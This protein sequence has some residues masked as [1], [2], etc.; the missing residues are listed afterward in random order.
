[1]NNEIPC[2]DVLDSPLAEAI[3]KHISD[4]RYYFVF[5]SQIAADSWAQAVFRHPEI[6]ALEPGRFLSWDRFLALIREKPRNE[7]I[8]PADHY[9]RYLWACGALK[10]N[11]ENPF[12]RALVKPDLAPPSRYPAWLASIANRLNFMEDIARREYNSESHNAEILDFIILS[13]K[14][15]IFLERNNL[16]EESSLPLRFPEK[17]KFI[18][19]GASAYKD[20]LWYRSMLEKSGCTE[21]FDVIPAEPGR[22]QK[23]HRFENFR[24]EARWIFA[25]IRSMLNNGKTPGDFAISVPALQP[26][27]K[28]YLS[29]FAHEYDISITFRVGEKLSSSPFGLLLNLIAAAIDDTLSQQSV[30]ALARQTLFV[31]KQPGAFA[32]LMEFSRMFSIPRKN[33]GKKFMNRV[34][35]MTF[36]DAQFEG[37][38]AL[39]D[40]YLLLQKK[41]SAIAAAASFQSLREALFDFRLTFIEDSGISEQSEKLLA[42]IFEELISLERAAQSL[43]G[44]SLTGNTFQRFRA[45]LDTIQYAPD[46]SDMAVSVY[47]YHSG[48]LNAAPVHFVLDASQDAVDS[49]QK[50]PSLPE[51]IKKLLP[52]DTSYESYILRSFDCVNAIYCFADTALSGFCVPHPWFSAEHIQT[53]FVNEEK[54]LN[55]LSF[56]AREKKAWIENRPENLQPLT[57]GQQNAALGIFDSELNGQPLPPPLFDQRKTDTRQTIAADNVVD[58]IAPALH[59]SS[60][61]INPAALGDYSACPFRWFLAYIVRLQN[62]IPSEPLMIGSIL[63]DCIKN[64]VLRISSKQPVLRKE[65]IQAYSD[66]VID[67]IQQGIDYQTRKSGHGARPF[68]EAHFRRMTSRLLT[69]LD[70]EA[71]LQ[72]AGWTVGEFEKSFEKHFE[73]LSVIFNGRT[74]RLM[75]RREGSEMACLLIDY[76]KKYIPQ[77]KHLL[78]DEKTGQL[79]ELQIPGYILLLTEAG[80]LVVSAFYYSIENAKKQVVLGDESR[81]AAPDAQSYFK[82]L[83]ALRAMLEKASEGIW[84]G[85]ITAA[86]PFTKTCSN[87][88]YRPICRANYSSERH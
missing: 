7:T 50:F 24:T 2:R 37:K 14:Y 34:W 21:F 25:N 62:K 35:S 41:L 27:M 58:C 45:F 13:E 56:H 17:S 6:E 54:Q 3:V 55:A 53:V 18:L 85:R 76:K 68:L 70:L 12:L 39:H 84:S 66:L 72:E 69:Y 80:F 8:R 61:K 52:D 86:S 79:A 31:W 19:F 46:S 5:P 48:I 77:K 42:R 65:A 22:S 9:T 74:D 73:Q 11:A 38:A 32:K 1:M 28:A 40:F 59:G 47:P 57:F 64:I 33:G 29:V 36:S 49:A 44:V 10:E 71:E 82:E 75:F 4:R 15:R 60:I 26:D 16:F 23:L 78:L 51:S 63:H 81:A 83:E 87:C 88:Q 30:E 43:T 20:I 67:A